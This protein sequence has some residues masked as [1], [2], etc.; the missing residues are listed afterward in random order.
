MI[1]TTSLKL[2]SIII[3]ITVI[4]IKIRKLRN[5]NNMHSKIR[6]TGKIELLLLEIEYIKI[7]YIEYIEYNK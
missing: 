5:N 2:K 3:I 7:E 4:I 1:K 6:T